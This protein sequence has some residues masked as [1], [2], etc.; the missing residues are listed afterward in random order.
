MFDY[1]KLY[2]LFKK[3]IH[4]IYIFNFVLYSLHHQVSSF[5]IGKL[6][7]GVVGLR[8]GK[9]VFIEKWRI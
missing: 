7:K 2:L 6:W 3:K 9:K 5:A 4:Y 8:L 1:T